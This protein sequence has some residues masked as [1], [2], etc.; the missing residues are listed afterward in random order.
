M[1]VLTSMADFIL[2]LPKAEL[3]VHLEGSV[4]PET[5]HELDPATPIEEFRALYRYADF[6]SFLKAFGVI[7]KLLRTPDAYALAARRLLE[8]LAAQN[9]QYAEIILAA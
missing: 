7:G 9:V 6:E 2:D 1:R 8:R 3:H 5:L 4:E